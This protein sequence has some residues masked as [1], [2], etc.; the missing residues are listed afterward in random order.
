MRVLLKL[1]PAAF[2]LALLIAGAVTAFRKS[3]FRDGRIHIRILILLTL[4]ILVIIVIFVLIHILIPC[5]HPH[6]E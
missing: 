4:R 3:R 2:L 5:P 6:P 1:I